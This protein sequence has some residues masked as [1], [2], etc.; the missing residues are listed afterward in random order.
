MKVSGSTIF[1]EEKAMNATPITTPT[2]ENSNQNHGEKESTSGVM[3]K[4]MTGSGT[5]ASNMAMESGKASMETAILASGRI[6][7]LTA[8]VF[9]L[10]ATVT[11]M[12]VS[13]NNA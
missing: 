9:T 7:E 4:F 2:S 8:T 5:K 11:A 6:P 13:G 10:G 12:K 3:V 1:V